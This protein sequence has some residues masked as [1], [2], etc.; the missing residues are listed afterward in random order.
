MIPVILLGLYIYSKDSVKEPKSLLL[1][2]FSSGLLSSVLVIIM[3]IITALLLP[4]LYLS[5]NYSKFGF[6]KL[7]AML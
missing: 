2:L 1:I 5:D 6:F 4:D 3:N 7:F